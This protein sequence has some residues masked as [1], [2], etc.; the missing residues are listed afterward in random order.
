MDRNTAVCAT[1]LLAASLLPAADPSRTVV[2]ISLD[3]FPAY[4]LEDPKLPVPTL[5]RLMREGASAA[6]MS[7][8]NPSVTWPNHTT[9]VTGVPPS[10]HGVLYNGMLV[11]ESGTPPMRVEPWR[12]KAE[13][14]RVPTVYDVAFGAG[15]TTAQVDWVAIHN[16]GTI[17]WAFPEQPS[18]G[19]KIEM[20]MI[21]E[22]LVTK[23]E[24]EEFVKSNIVFR[25]QIWTRAAVHLIH[26]HQPNLL[27]F[28][29]LSLDSTHH[30]YGPRSPAALTAMAMLDAQVRQILDALEAAGLKDRATV[31]VVSDHGFKTTLKGV[32][33]NAILKKAG[34][35]KAAYVVPEGGTAM[36]YLTDEANRADRLRE[37]SKLFNNVE[38]VSAR[39]GA[40]AALDMPEPLENKQMAD[41]L[42]VASDRYTFVGGDGDP[43][44]FDLPRPGGSHGYLH[45]DPEMN[46]IFIAWG[47]G[48]KPGARL[49]R[50]RNL[51]VAPT[52]AALLGLDLKNV[53]GTAL[54]EI[55]K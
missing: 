20:E 40:F 41:L 39:G 53:D 18:A 33:A 23:A 6:A 5:R 1:L 31:L 28:H 44:V 38:G 52:I 45:S 7:V 24:I 32:R 13:M 50:I 14:V 36:L 29:L 43:A 54:R 15:L 19:G 34:L 22:G 30:T 12:D 25:D 46:A 47:N 48:I 3:G 26:K 2:V 21:A 37:L 27:L 9:M 8:V 42:L 55:L 11:R 16:P 4:A 17:T 51:D 10:K 49:D 35:A